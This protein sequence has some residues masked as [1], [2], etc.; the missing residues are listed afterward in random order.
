MFLNGTVKVTSATNVLDIF[1]CLRLKNPLNVGDWMTPSSSREG[2]ERTY[3]GGP[4]TKRQ[5]V[6]LDQCTM[7]KISVMYIAIHNYQNSIEIQDL[8][9]G[10]LQQ[11]CNL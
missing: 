6:T 9:L 10:T 11:K 4:F 7:L 1:H 5:S 8:T 3:C 2:R